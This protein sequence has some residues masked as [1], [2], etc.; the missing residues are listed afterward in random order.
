MNS[1]LE[2]LFSSEI[3]FCG[4]WKEENRLGRDREEV[5]KLKVQVKALLG[6]EQTDLWKVY[7]EKTQQLENKECQ[8]EFEKGF[9]TAANLALEVF[10]RA[11]DAE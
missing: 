1:I 5:C 10:R 2:L 4:S 3:P 7:Q 9:L 8:I 11:A 6:E